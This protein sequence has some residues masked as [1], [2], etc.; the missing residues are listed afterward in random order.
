MLRLFELR[1]KLQLYASR[2]AN[3]ENPNGL[4]QAHAVGC[5]VICSHNYTQNRICLVCDCIKIFN[6]P[7]KQFERWCRLRS[8]KF[9]SNTIICDTRIVACYSL[10]G[11]ISALVSPINFPRRK[12]NADAYVYQVLLPIHD[13]RPGRDCLQNKLNNH[14]SDTRILIVERTKLLRKSLLLRVLFV[15]ERQCTDAWK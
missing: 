4:R 9:G 10:I 2:L 13:L 3:L 7:I 1:Y 11:S 12:T 15:A 14:C 8:I 6:A 5:D